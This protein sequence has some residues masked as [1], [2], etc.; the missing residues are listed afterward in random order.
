M[1]KPISLPDVTQPAEALAAVVA[2]RRMADNLERRAVAH[3]LSQGWT[4]ADVAEA[5]G[6]TKQAAHKR[7]APLMSKP[8][9]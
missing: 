5:L 8:A 7:L 6:I 9:P 3:A 1:Q 4:W 2:L